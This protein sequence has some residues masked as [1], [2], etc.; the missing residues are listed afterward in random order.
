LLVDIADRAV[1]LLESVI[2]S[3]EEACST[4]ADIREEELFDN[5]EINQKDAK[6]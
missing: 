5:Y 1:L 6:L 3:G 2:P 4:A